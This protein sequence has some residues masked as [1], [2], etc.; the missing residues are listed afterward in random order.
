MDWVDIGWAGD[1]SNGFVDADIG[2][3]V[4]ARDTVKVVDGFP[5]DAGGRRT[6]G[7][8]S[9]GLI[10][11]ERPSIR[12]R[13]SIA[14]SKLPFTPLSIVSFLR[15]SANPNSRSFASFFAISSSLS[16]PKLAPKTLEI[17]GRWPDSGLRGGNCGLDRDARE[18]TSFLDLEKS[19]N[20]DD[21]DRKLNFPGVFGG[22]GGGV[23]SDSVLPVWCFLWAAKP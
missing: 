17:L 13:A 18:D 2:R 15:S 4:S 11:G 7:N 6:G 1:M 9:A 10:N 14:L 21:A 5:A 22:K 12:I 3:A 20:V 23:S 19:G 16:P 8:S